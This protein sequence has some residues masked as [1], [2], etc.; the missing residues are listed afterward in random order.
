MINE[1]P[2]SRPST[3]QMDNL[4]E[5]WATVLAQGVRDVAKAECTRR[6]L[7]ELVKSGQ[8]QDI[9]RGAEKLH[10]CVE[11]VEMLADRL[12]S[13]ERAGFE[14]GAAA[15][16]ALKKE[17]TTNI[18]MLKGLELRSS[19]VYA[20]LDEATEWFWD[21]GRELC[22]IRTIYS[23]FPALPKLDDFRQMVVDAPDAYL[24][25]SIDKVPSEQRRVYKT[26]Q[27]GRDVHQG[28]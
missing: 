20:G 16:K 22:A 2:E 6:T 26:D 17:L 8:G 10:R 11:A 1:D 9:L 15:R 18:R 19:L 7:V 4:L 12:D 14:V 13:Y 24:K 28:C 5:L 27:G 25:F 21:D 23:L 3:E